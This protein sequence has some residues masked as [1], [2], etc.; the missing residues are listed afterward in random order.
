MKT[1]QRKIS[2]TFCFL[3]LTSTCKTT[4]SRGLQ[5][6][7]TTGSGTH[8]AS[9]CRDRET[10]TSR[11]RQTNF[12]KRT[13]S[14][15]AVAKPRQS[16]VLFTLDVVPSQNQVSFS[17]S[18]DK[19]SSECSSKAAEEDGVSNLDH[20]GSNCHKHQLTLKSFACIFKFYHLRSH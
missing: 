1:T 5:S 9:F 2:T 15:N 14:V 11:D 20:V 3:I 12:Q 7:S 10:F 8:F 17:S 16:N 4:I 6:N 19:D 13:T 18:E